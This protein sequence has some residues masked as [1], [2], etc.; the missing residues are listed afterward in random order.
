MSAARASS[1][2]T[3]RASS[4]AAPSRPPERAPRQR[5][6]RARRPDLRVVDRR[7]RPLSGVA[8]S[9]A[10]IVVLFVFTA[11]AAHI[12]L[13]ERQRQLDSVRA[14]I[15]AAQG[16]REE[17][18]RR[19]SQLQSPEEVLRLAKDRLGMVPAAEP[20][21]VPPSIVVIGPGPT[22]PTTVP[23]EAP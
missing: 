7:Q 8:L 5:P 18:L 2:A 3:V 22:T 6:E 1:A 20:E 10:L 11:L 14:D 13:I 17:L 21:L 12:S 4:P 16:R 9:V 23:A 19:E 15:T